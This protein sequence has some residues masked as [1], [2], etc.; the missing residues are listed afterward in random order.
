[1][2][3]LN[4]IGIS[5]RV[6]N[7]VKD[8]LF[9]RSIRVRIGTALSRKYL[10]DN[11]THQ[12][13]VISPLLFSIM[14]NYVFSQVPPDISRSL[15]ADDGALW[16]RGRNVGHIKIKIQEAISVV[17][18]WSY[19]WGFKFSVEKTKSLIFTRKKKEIN[20]IEV[21]NAQTNN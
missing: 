6:F 1:M 10:V 15:F 8:F 21:K 19:S 11:G 18:K 20:G 9:G 16:K 4:N 17:E 7:W 2:I 5:G 3:K 14:I 12:G 13:S